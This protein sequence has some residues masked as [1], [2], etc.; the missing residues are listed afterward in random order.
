VPTGAS[1]CGRRRAAGLLLLG[2]PAVLAACRFPRDSGDTLGAV[3]ARGEMTVSAAEHPPWVSLAGTTPRGVEVALVERFARAVGV[4][5]EW[6]PLPA[7][8]ALV[9]LESGEAELATGGFTR[10]EVTVDGS[11]APS[12]VYHEEAIVVAGPPGTALPDGIDGARVFVPPDVVAEGRIRRR[13]GIPVSDPDGADFAALPHWQVAARGLAQTGIVLARRQHVI[14][15]PKGE[16]AWLMGLE[17]LLRESAPE[18]DRLLR[19][20]AG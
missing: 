1:V 14:A 12:L 13:G 4:A 3:I 2:A 11:G 19:E 9:A 20:A 17:T 5:I 18:V 6:R 10:E 7:P 16:N 15:V 8:L